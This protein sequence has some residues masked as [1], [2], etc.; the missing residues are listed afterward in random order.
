MWILAALIGLAAFAT[1]R[2]VA[3]HAMTVQ[4]LQKYVAA[5]LLDPARYEADS[6]RFRDLGLAQGTAHGVITKQLARLIH[7]LSAPVARGA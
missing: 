7:D 4:R 3:I 2:A 5:L 6:R 1:V